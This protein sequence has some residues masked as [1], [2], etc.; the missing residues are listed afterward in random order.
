[1]LR[2]VYVL[3]IFIFHYVHLSYAADLE[4]DRPDQATIQKF[5][6]QQRQQGNA[7]ITLLYRPSPNA[8]PFSIKNMKAQL[9]HDG[10]WQQN[11]EV[12]TLTPQQGAGLHDNYAML[13]TL[14]TKFPEV[15]LWQTPLSPSSYQGI[16]DESLWFAY[17]TLFKLFLDYDILL[18]IPAG[19]EMKE[20]P[21]FFSHEEYKNV[22]IVGAC[23]QDGRLSRRSNFGPMVR[24][25]THQK[26]EANSPW[27]DPE[28]TN[29]SA[30]AVAELV[31]Y[32]RSRRPDLNASD[33][34]SILL[35]TARQTEETKEKMPLGGILDQEMALYSINDS[36]R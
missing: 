25:A 9:E 29:D 8:M 35:E 15:F 1:M 11:M 3:S 26:Y 2:Y 21:K 33:I 5:V 36:K 32:M 19:D 10:F 16:S 23:D 30:F 31:F 28:N 24:I 22:L 7:K 18:I 6:K 13:E 14:V 4:Y 27:I 20:M 34:I 12:I 17:E